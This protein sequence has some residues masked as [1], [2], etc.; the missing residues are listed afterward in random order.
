MAG[1]QKASLLFALVCLLSWSVNSFYLDQLHL[2]ISSIK[3]PRS[4]KVREYRFKQ[5]H[6][7]SSSENNISAKYQVRSKLLEIALQKLRED[8]NVSNNINKLL[9]KQLFELSTKYDINQRNTSQIMKQLK[10]TKSDK[11][12]TNSRSKLVANQLETEQIKN[13]DLVADIKIYKSRLIILENVYRESQ[14]AIRIVKKDHCAEIENLEVIS[15]KK[16][17]NEKALQESLLSMARKEIDGLKVSYMS[18]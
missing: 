6:C 16:R 9:E 13:H 1:Y 11:L 4:F 18:T 12:E 14:E 17:E 2:P 15:R 7:E 10:E 5:Y 3:Q 8:K